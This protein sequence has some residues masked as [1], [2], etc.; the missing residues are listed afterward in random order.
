MAFLSHIFRG[1]A[2][3]LT[4]QKVEKRRILAHV[5]AMLS[6]KKAQI[7]RRLERGWKAAQA[8]PALFF[9]SFPLL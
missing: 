8:V 3:R 1:Q 6:Q 4:H 5:R 7:K 2:L 9:L